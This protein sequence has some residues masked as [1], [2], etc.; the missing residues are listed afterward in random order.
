MYSLKIVENKGCQRAREDELRYTTNQ[1]LFWAA[2]A[3]D[4]LDDESEAARLDNSRGLSVET[5]W[6]PSCQ[7]TWS[8]MSYQS[9]WHE[10][11]GFL[12]HPNIYSG[13]AWVE[14]LL[15]EWLK[16]KG[17]TKYGNGNA[18]WQWIVQYALTGCLSRYS[19]RSILFLQGILS[20]QYEKAIE[21]W[22]LEV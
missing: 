10:F 16:V 14:I 13:A 21:I 6:K 18:W 12:V 15:S 5:Q 19:N 22:T 1:F 8:K 11:N 4:M 2:A 9:K 20:L 7:R 17:I 3:L